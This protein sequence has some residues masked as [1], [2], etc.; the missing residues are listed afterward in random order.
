MWA[1]FLLR[2]DVEGTEFTIRVNCDSSNWILNLSRATGMLAP[3]WLRLSEFD[4]N[5]IHW[6]GIKNRE[7]D[8]LSGLEIGGG[9][10]TD[11]NENIP[12]AVTDLDED[13]K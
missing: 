7:A 10:S 12:V 8:T 3:W 6:A 4:V 9:D 2:L 13:R 5:S 1:E 11:I